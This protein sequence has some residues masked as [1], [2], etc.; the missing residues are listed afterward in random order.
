MRVITAPDQQLEILTVKAETVAARLRAHRTFCPCCSVAGD[1]PAPPCDR[2]QQLERL[3]TAARALV[4]AR[5]K[6]LR[7]R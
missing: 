7:G 1:Q 6:A 4:N 5:Q 3:Q 2:L